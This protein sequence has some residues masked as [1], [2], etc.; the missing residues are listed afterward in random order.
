MTLEIGGYCKFFDINIMLSLQHFESFGSVTLHS[1]FPLDLF[2]A[3]V[4]H[5]SYAIYCRGP[6]KVAV[7]VP[8]RLA[9]SWI[10]KGSFL[11]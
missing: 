8:V 10:F 2:I 9:N 1:K 7:K 5:L 6:V 11:R 3:N 4:L